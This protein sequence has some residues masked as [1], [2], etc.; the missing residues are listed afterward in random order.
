MHELLK[1]NQVFRA[2]GRL[3]IE[4]PADRFLGIGR[5]ELLERIQASG[6]ISRAARE[7][8]MSYKKAWDLV[9]SMNAQARR[10]L[11]STQAGGPHGGGAALTPAGEQALAEFQAMQARFAEFLAVETARLYS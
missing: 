8:Q 10:P 5:L 7:M 1:E 4:G 9:A 3:W 11:V 2:N 6:S